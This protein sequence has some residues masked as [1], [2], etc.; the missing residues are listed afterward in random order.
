M[1]IVAPSSAFFLPEPTGQNNGVDFLGLR[2]ANL[3][4][5][6]DLIPGTNNVTAYIRPFSLLS[7]IFW[8]FHA[9]CADG[10]I[11]EPNGT[12][13]QAFRERIE[14]LFTWGARI[15]DCP[16]IPGKQAE[17]PPS[18]SAGRV[19]LT[20]KD[21]KRVQDSTSLVAAL[22]YGPASKI[23]TGLGLLMPV[24][25][26]AGFF[27]T[28]GQGVRLAQELDARL[29][30]DAKRYDRLLATLGTVKA[31]ENDARALWAL[32]RPDVISVAEQSAF[33]EVLHD[34]NTVGDYQSPIGKRSSTLG[35]VR[36]HLAHA[37]TSQSAEDIRKG[38]MLSRRPDGGIYAVPTELLEARDKW[39]ILQ[40]RQLQRLALESMLSWCETKILSGV[41]DTADLVGS[42]AQEWDDSNYPFSA[43]DRLSDALAAIEER[44]SNLE[45]FI[46]CCRTGTV[47]PPLDLIE[48]IQEA[49]VASDG[50]YAAHCFLGLLLCAAFSGCVD[51]NTPGLRLGGPAR[52]PLYHLRKRL[53]GLGDASIREA[54]S[55]ML[56]AMVISQHFATAVNRFDG[57]NQ[58]LRIAIEETGLVPL[59]GTRWR[60]TVTEDRLPMLLSLAAGCG[61][62]GVGNDGGYVSG[63][64]G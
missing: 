19:P 60:P 61:V 8:K 7:W 63:A 17:P 20:F 6:A 44:F 56:E 36:L 39:V 52:I 47:S 24:P 50:K 38:M 58:R 59:V 1:N 41:R 53:V 2:Q 32:W 29:R 33:R 45:E 14:I 46:E 3:D 40:V 34:V 43:A 42:F 31:S 57:Q 13:L 37:G 18:E 22:W 10:G 48:A 15:E 5:M 54:M 28:V 11:D 62:L 49:F 64:V 25:G 16:N 55:Y 51:K 26:R 21:W 12:S 27:R 35:L 30:S 4:M 9:L 23:V